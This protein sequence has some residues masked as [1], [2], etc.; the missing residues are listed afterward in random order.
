MPGAAG[1]RLGDS[2]LAF[3]IMIATGGTITTA[4]DVMI[5]AVSAMRCRGRPPGSS[6]RLRG[7]RSLS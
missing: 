1:T 3:A 6:T 7:S 5:A 2:S 4:T